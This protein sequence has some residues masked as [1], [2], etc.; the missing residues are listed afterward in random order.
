[1]LNLDDFS[2]ENST[3]RPQPQVQYVDGIKYL[4]PPTHPLDIQNSF[5][6]TDTVTVEIVENISLEIVD[7]ALTPALAQVE[8]V[9]ETLAPAPAPV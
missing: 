7:P 3:T 2:E 1:M 5:A 9:V 4:V 8:E 6:N